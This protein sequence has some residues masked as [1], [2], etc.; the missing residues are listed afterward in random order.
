M[1][2]I[3]QTAICLMRIKNYKIVY[4]YVVYK[5]I[6]TRRVPYSTKTTKKKENIKKILNAW[7]I[8]L[9]KIRNYS[10]QYTCS[11]TNKLD[12]YYN[13]NNITLLKLKPRLEIDWHLNNG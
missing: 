11:L 10:S 9:Y 13:V 1:K 6:H 2:S 7:I 8:L 5:N 4:V 12:K 3:F